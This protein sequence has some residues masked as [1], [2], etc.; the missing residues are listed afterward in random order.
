MLCAKLASSYYLI[1]ASQIKPLQER[2]CDFPRWTPAVALGPARTPGAAWGT[3]IRG[4]GCPNVLPL[5]GRDRGDLV[6]SGAWW[7]LS[8]GA[9]FLL[10]GPG[11]WPLAGAPT[12]TRGRRLL[13][14]RWPWERPTGTIEKPVQQHLFWHR[15]EAL[16]GCTCVCCSGFPKP[17]LVTLV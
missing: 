1:S 15:V 17:L 13:P 10:T 5:P 9:V 4:R 2:S 14:A 8:S 11:F 3:E 16:E 7:L 6:L 12:A